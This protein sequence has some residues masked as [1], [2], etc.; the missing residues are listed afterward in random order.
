MHYYPHDINKFRAGTSNF[1]R[2][3]RW[4]Y[5][6]ML[7]IYYDTEK[8]LNKDFDVLCDDLAVTSS[9]EMAAVSRVLRRKFALEQDGYHHHICDSVI[10]DYK[11]AAETARLNGSKGGRPPK[12]KPAIT[13]PVI[14][15][16]PAGSHSDLTGMPDETGLKANQ[17]SLINN[18]LTTTPVPHGTAQMSCPVGSLV[19]L[20]HECMPD[21]PRAKEITDERKRHIR[22]RWKQ[23]AKMTC[24]PFGY[25]SKE[26]GLA[27]WR[28]FFE[29]CATSD[30]LTGKVPGTFGKPTFIANIDFLFSPSGFIKCLENKYHRDTE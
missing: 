30:F 14:L 13:Q 5:R 21:N 4:I 1:S 25:D 15:G 27:A 22:S 9:E 19:N 26:D 12:V 7:D 10:A 11:K 23:A 8:P 16:L 2:I 18:Q 6:D 24:K 20:Y 28:V 3:E 17:E 29:V